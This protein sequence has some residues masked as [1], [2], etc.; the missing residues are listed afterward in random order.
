MEAMIWCHNHACPKLVYHSNTLVASTLI[1]TFLEMLKFSK[2]IFFSK[3][4]F[5]LKKK[6]DIKSSRIFYLLK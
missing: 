6:E 1:V 5:S 4:S 3:I 2:K